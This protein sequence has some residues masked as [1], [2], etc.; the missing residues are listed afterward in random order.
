MPGQCLICR[1][2][3]VYI[4]G[5]AADLMDDQKHSNSNI[6]LTFFPYPIKFQ[7]QKISSKR[8]RY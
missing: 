3:K 6:Y 1:R 5:A 2:G 7:P 4:G 8:T